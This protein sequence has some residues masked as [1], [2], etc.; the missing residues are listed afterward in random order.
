[1]LFMRRSLTRRSRYNLLL[2]TNSSCREVSTHAESL[3]EFVSGI[4]TG[5]ID[6]DQ[7]V[8]RLSGMAYEDVDTFAKIDHNR[9][10]RAGVPEVVFGEGK[11]SNQVAN[12]MSS[13]IEYNRNSGRLDGVVMTSRVTSE[14]ASEVM[15]SVE[16]LVY[17]PTARILAYKCPNE[18]GRST[19]EDVAGES[20][21]DEFWGPGK[22]RVA[23]LCA[24]TADLP[25]A[26][27][28]AVVAEL[29]GLSVARV[30][31]VG[32]AGLH[33]LLSHLPRL[34]SAHVCVV[35]AGMDGALPSVVGGLMA[36]P[37]IAVPTS[38]GYGMSLG[39]VSAL[40]SM[41]NSCSAA[42]AVQN[43]DNGLG[44]AMLAV[45][46]IGVS[47]RMREEEKDRAKND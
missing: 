35:A 22:G 3:R 32:V 18:D 38:V 46:I 7:A 17:H 15:S 33:R 39:G 29:C 43:I 2:T 9:S 47:K 42:V 21:A 30:Y 40:L 34:Q 36:C 45:K 41:L 19:S 11:T 8:S 26:E 28:A 23:V 24:G 14:M 6:V 16:G 12:I 13:M 4:A 31:D 1:M 27:E 44:A 10:L 5:K 25:V 20:N 37:V